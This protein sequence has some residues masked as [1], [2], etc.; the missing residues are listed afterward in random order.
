MPESKPIELNRIRSNTFEWKVVVPSRFLYAYI[1][2]DVDRY[3]NFS[4]FWNEFFVRIL[5]N[6]VIQHWAA[7]REKNPECARAQCVQYMQKWLCSYE[8]E[9]FARMDRTYWTRRPFRSGWTCFGFSFAFYLFTHSF[10]HS[11]LFSSL[12]PNQY[13]R[14]FF[15]PFL[16]MATL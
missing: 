15:L 7:K 11:F 3:V 1:F 16:G 10:I 5:C 13:R 9:I 4:F 8:C 2:G 12:S 14:Y 6:A